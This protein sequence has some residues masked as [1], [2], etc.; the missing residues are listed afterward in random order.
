HTATHILHWALRKV[1]GAHVKQAGSLVEDDRLRFDFTHFEAMDT[2]QIKKV[3]D[4]VNEKILQA[5]PVKAFTTTIDYAKE[6]QA[7]AFFNEK[8]GEF[9]R[10]V[11]AGD[12]SKELCGGTHVTNT[13]FINLFKINSEGSV[14][15]NLRRIEAFTGGRLFKRFREEE[16]IVKGASEVLKVAPAGLGKKIAGLNK[17]MVKLKKELSKAKKG[18]SAEQIE[19]I[20]A[21]S[22]KING[23][24][25]LTYRLDD[26][27]IE[28][29]REYA[30][31]LRNK[32]GNSAIMLAS[33]KD[34]KAL[35]LAA[36]SKEAVNKGFD[37]GAWL[38]EILPII[39]GGGGGKANLAQAGGKEPE[40]IPKALDKAL[41][42]ADNWASTR[43]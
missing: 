19:E 3:E 15:A 12:F 41:E 25:V 30:D 40:Q 42:F 13:A 9:V 18:G 33:K 29:L 10:V 31:I 22:K 17:D 36:V 35:V 16:E 23:F 1:F 11:E 2:K 4:L 21:S 43:A 37:A 28:T 39:K 8:Y 38:K 26:S 5:L 6:I 14:G 24:N 7:I 27:D 34:N 32:L 20:A